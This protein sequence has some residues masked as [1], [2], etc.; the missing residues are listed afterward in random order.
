MPAWNQ[1]LLKI[2]PVMLT[3]FFII[4]L[5]AQRKLT[6]AA[7]SDS[8]T[9]EKMSKALGLGKYGCDSHMTLNKSL[10]FSLRCLIC[11]KK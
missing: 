4:L 1:A 2:R 5:K 11:I 10:F 7:I 3:L 8:F 9:V 6:L